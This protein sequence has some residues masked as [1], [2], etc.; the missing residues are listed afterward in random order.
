M[1]ELLLPAG[2]LENLKIAVENG[3]DA[4]Y[5]GIKRFNAR[6]KAGNF[7]ISE[8]K[9]VIDYAHENG[10]R[11]YVTL[12]TLIK[13]NEIEDFFKS[14]QEIYLAGADAVII[15][16]ISFA[17]V[18]KEN[19]PD[20]EVHAS[21]Q[22]RIQNLK[23]LKYFDRIIL[24]R[25]LSK[26]EIIEIK[27]NSNLPIEIFV[28]GALC[29][30]ISGLCLMSSVIGRRSGNRGICAQPCRKKYNDDYLMSM[31][32]LS[33]IKKIKEIKSIGVESVKIEGRLRSK[34]YVKYVTQVYRKA[35]DGK[36]I[37]NQDVKKLESVFNRK[38]TGGFYSKDEEK[39]SPQNIKYKEINHE[40]HQF[41]NIKPE[42]KI[43]ERISKQIS[44]P[45]LN[46]KKSNLGFYVKVENIEGVKQ[47]IR[48]EN[49]NTIF[50][51]VD[52]KDVV[53]A[54]KIIKETNKKFYLALPTI[55]NDSDINYYKKKIETI[56]P[57][58]LLINSYNFPTK[59]D[60]IYDYGI[61]AFNDYDLELFGKS[62]ISPELSIDDLKQ[63]KNKDFLVLVHGN[64]TV[65]TTKNPLPQKLKYDEKFTFPV[66][67]EKDYYKILNAKEIA[68]L[69][70]VKILKQNGI[71]QYFFDLDKNVKKWLDIYTKI[72][73]GEKLNFKKL[74][75]GF[76]LGH[77][78]K[79]V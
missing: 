76:T 78:N 17:K 7:S 39:I 57:D 55:M 75:K 63:F 25:E 66:K 19:F 51:Y 70:N 38:Y 32:D 54:K 64:L 27:N 5:L 45:Q 35:L 24:P 28:H 20:L 59:L 40:I 33:L 10:V 16:E 42:I 22:A 72:L 21:T 41:Q 47:A 12:N 13:N 8:L 60:T 4:V 14:V 29:F 26:E 53:E 74:G 46:E 79:G 6:V 36:E 2:N 58:G 18:I 30:C 73:N 1:V 37:T 50:Y 69:D 43:K 15:Q 23:E 34:E 77:F 67:K 68:I 71:N 49:V 61:N 62:M 48:F 11:V 56:N 65:M 31:K 9:K 3:A 44:I 52:K